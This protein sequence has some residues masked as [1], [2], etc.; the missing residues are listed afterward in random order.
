[1]VS[2]RWCLTHGREAANRFVAAV[3][4]NEPGCLLG[5]GPAVCQE[6]EPDDGGAHA[7]CR[8]CGWQRSR[9]G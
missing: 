5:D 9:H 8:H 4:P 2:A 1:M 7:W 3:C 6:Y